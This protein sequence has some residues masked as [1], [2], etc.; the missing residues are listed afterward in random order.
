MYSTTSNV[1]EG[2]IILLQYCNEKDSHNLSANDETL[3]FSGTDRRVSEDDY[4]K[5]NRLG[6]FVTEHNDK[7]SY[8]DYDFNNVWQIFV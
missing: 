3:Y 4:N 1:V 8:A 5:L 6:W 7:S 2:I